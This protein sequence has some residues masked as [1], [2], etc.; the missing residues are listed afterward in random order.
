[1][2]KYNKIYT[3]CFDLN[4]SQAN[5][6]TFYLKKSFDFFRCIQI[7]D[8]HC[9]HYLFLYSDCVHIHLL[10]LNKNL[11]GKKAN[12]FFSPSSS[13]SSSFGSVI[14]FECLPIHFALSKINV[15]PVYNR[16]IERREKV[17]MFIFTLYR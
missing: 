2:E 4:Y 14:D 15:V 7:Y 8:M 11:N 9:I 16:K 12:N 13:H 1:M 3:K 10:K 17:Y 5:L 6:I